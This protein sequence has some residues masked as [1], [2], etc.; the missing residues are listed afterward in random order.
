MSEFELLVDLYLKSERQ[1]PGSEEGTLCALELC[2]IE[3]KQNLNIAD[4]GCGTGAQTLTLAKHL[5]GKITAVDLFDEFLS[6]LVKRKNT[7]NLG[8]EITTLKASM[9]DLPFELDSLDLIWSEGAIYNMGFE[10]GVNYWSQFLKPGGHLAVSEI[11]WTTNQRPNEIDEFWKAAY[12]EVAT[13]AEK[14]RILESAGYSLRG[15]F[16]LPESSWINNYYEP[17]EKQF[18]PFLERHE[19]SKEAHEIVEESKREIELYEKFK[20][21]YSYGFYIAQ[22]ES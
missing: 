19:N 8:C 22:K 12:P 16:I 17:L 13:T 9:D 10:K 14:I 3:G 15:Y 11:T 21:Y 7:E 5:E 6:E 2:D 1:G 4:I 18:K 20:K